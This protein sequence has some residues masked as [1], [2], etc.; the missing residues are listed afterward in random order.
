[1]R[2]IV[3]LALFLLAGPALAHSIDFTGAFAAEASGATGTGSLS[4]EYD[5]DGH[6]LLIDASWSGLSGTTTIAHIHC[7]TTAPG[8][9]TAGIALGTGT[10]LNLPAWPVGVTS[11][12]YLHVIDL[13]DPAM[14]SATFL[15]SSGGTATGA[16]QSLIANLTS[17]NAYF[18]IHSSTFPSGEIRT[19]VSVVPEPTTAGLLV[20][21]L[22]ALVWARRARHGSR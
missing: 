20:T 4:L 19:F 14:Y 18:N 12:S 2:I 10:P 17:R 6:T 15:T 13:T 16:E 3:A 22:A 5:T 8:S 7:C 21:G 11:G 1:M 9:G